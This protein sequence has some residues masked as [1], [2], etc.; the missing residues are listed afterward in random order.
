MSTRVQ[1]VATAA[2][3]TVGLVACGTTATGGSGVAADATVDPTATPAPTPTPSHTPRPTPAP[4]P[5]T[6]DDDGSCQ[7]VS[8]FANIFGAGRDTAPAPGG[9]GAGELPPEWPLPS[10]ETRVVSFPLV[11]GEIY[12]RIGQAPS[13]GPGGETLLSTDVQSFEGIS[14]IVHGEKAMFLVGVF[15]TDEEPADPAPVRLDFSENEDFDLL[16]P[17]IGQTFLIGDGIGR[18]YLVPQGAT[19]LFLGFAEGM[20]YKGPPG[21]YENNSGHLVV[22]VEVATE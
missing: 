22:S 21:W 9:G 1:L 15:L 20:F 11:T 2:L 12:G 14:G 18:R 7:N 10:G 17:E 3:I 8:A 4:C 5:T 6:T 19:R 16:E 13:N